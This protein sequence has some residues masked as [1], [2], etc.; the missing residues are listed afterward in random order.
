MSKMTDKE[1][2]KQKIKAIYPHIV[3]GGDIDKPCYNIHWYDIEQKTMIC[4]FSS[5]KLELVRKWLEEEFEVV[6]RDIDNLI[7]SQETEIERLNNELHSK[8]EYNSDNQTYVQEVEWHDIRNGFPTDENKTYLC[9]EK[10]ILSGMYLKSIYRYSNNLHKLDRYDFPDK[11]MKKGFYDYDGE[12]GY[13][14]RDKVLFW[15]ECPMLPEKII[16]NSDE[17]K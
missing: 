8:V 7:K 5:Y 1:N 12:Y 11:N 2:T 17:N 3:V 9:I 4:G 15:A 16:N 13:S 10:S 14:S 6:E